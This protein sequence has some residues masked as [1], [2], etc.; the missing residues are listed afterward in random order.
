MSYVHTTYYIRTPALV[1][2]PITFCQPEKGEPSL[3]DE[4]AKDI[5]EGIDAE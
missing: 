4:F 3:E 1:T 5:Y 2:S